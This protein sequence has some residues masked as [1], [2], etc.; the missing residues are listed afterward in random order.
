MARRGTGRRTAP[1]GAWP[2]TLLMRWSA[3]RSA[4]ASA[5]RRTTIRIWSS[6]LFYSERAAMP[7]A[8]AGDTLSSVPGSG[9]IKPMRDA[10][11][12]KAVQLLDLMI[13]HFADDAHWTRGRYDDENG[14]HCL[15]GALLHLS[16]KHSL[17]RAPAIALLQDA[18]PR[19]VC[20]STTVV[21]AAS[22]NCAPS[23]LRPAA[24][25]TIMRSKT[26]RPPRPRPGC[27]P[28]S[29]KKGERRRISQTRRRS[30]S[31]PNASPRNDRPQ[32]LVIRKFTRSLP[33]PC[34]LVGGPAAA[35]PSR[36]NT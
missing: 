35:G 27:L 7:I 23:S 8:A 14:G 19:P 12:V 22:P 2:P 31:P 26:G 17:P 9:A 1:E 4:L 24:S 29:A 25:P 3:G 6:R 20:T 5:T 33:P 10:E 36:G 21:A 32:Q 13:E 18:M 28:R 16:R 34:F 11:I 15:V 30:R